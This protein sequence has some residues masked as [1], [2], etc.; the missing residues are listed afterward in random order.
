MNFQIT[1]KPL[2]N[3]EMLEAARKMQ[4]GDCVERLTPSLAKTLVDEL[5]ELYGQGSCVFAHRG[6]AWTVWRK[7]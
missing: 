1:R 3:Q 7:K 4:P 6:K 2:P 5:T